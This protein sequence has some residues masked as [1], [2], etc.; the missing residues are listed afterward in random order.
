VSSNLSIVIDESVDYAIIEKLSAN[1]FNVY[2]IIDETPSISDESVLNIATEKNA[3]I[4]TE[5]KDFGELVFRFQ[6]S[7]RGILLVRM[8]SSKSFEKADAVLRVMINH[9]EELINNFSVLDENKLRI[10]K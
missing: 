3:L 2:A 7:H 4:I 10:R 1:N 5:D 8:I 9:Q 6:L